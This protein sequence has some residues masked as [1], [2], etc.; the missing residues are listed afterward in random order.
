[1]ADKTNG[2]HWGDRLRSGVDRPATSPGDKADD[3][4]DEEE[5]DD[6]DHRTGQHRGIVRDDETSNSVLEWDMEKE[7]S[8]T[9]LCGRR[10][11]DAPSP[12]LARF[13]T[14]FSDSLDDLELDNYSASPHGR[15]QR[16]RS[17]GD[18][19][20]NTVDGFM[21]HS[22]DKLHQS[23]RRRSSPS[24]C[25]HPLIPALSFATLAFFL[26]LAFGYLC[27]PSNSNVT[28]AG[29]TCEG[30]WDVR[31]DSKMAGLRARVLGN[32]TED[33]VVAA[34]RGQ[35]LGSEH[36]TVQWLRLQWEQAG[37]QDVKI[38]E[39]PG[40]RIKQRK[41]KFW[42]LKQEREIVSE[43]SCFLNSG[44]SCS[45][46]EYGNTS[47]RDLP[48]PAEVINVWYGRD[49]DLNMS[50]IVNLTGRI[51]LLKTG[52]APLLFKLRIL[53]KLEAHWA[54]V[55]TDPSCPPASDGVFLGSGKRVQHI[56]E[57]DDRWQD[58]VP[59]PFEYIS[60][61]LAW[62]LHPRDPHQPCRKTST[63]LSPPLV[64]IEV[65]NLQNDEHSYTITGCLPAAQEPDRFVLLAGSHGDVPS[66][67]VVMATLALAVSAARRSGWRPRRSL[68]FCSWGLA[69]PESWIEAHA[70]LLG[71]NAVAYVGIGTLA[72]P[73]GSLLTRASPSLQ[74][75][76]ADSLSE[77]DA[78]TTFRNS[79][80]LPMPPHAFLLENLGL[81]TITFFL[82]HPAPSPTTKSENVSPTPGLPST[83][84]LTA[85]PAQLAR[86]A[87]VAAY[88]AL[89][90]AD[91]PVLPFRVVDLALMV[92]NYVNNL[93]M[94]A[95]QLN[96]ST[97]YTV[98]QVLRS[99]AEDLQSDMN[100][101]AN[102]PAERPL[103]RLRMLNDA[104]QR[105]TRSFIASHLPLGLSRNILMRP[106]GVRH[107]TFPPLQAL[108]D[109]GE[110]NLL[111]NRHRSSNDS[112]ASSVL[113]RIFYALEA[114][115]VA[116][117]SAL[118]IFKNEE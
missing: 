67:A 42:M 83:M 103:F 37:L 36:Q 29:A 52:Y 70:G 27:Q 64:H 75:L 7:L 21:F 16:L 45:S 78:T 106:P 59:L 92:Q 63:L 74:Q 115:E 90:L 109:M 15:F 94:Q 118:D 82:P 105:L 33:A 111:S 53:A 39:H 46:D 113:M 22:T 34:A 101:P 100:R 81:A 71:G 73:Q 85:A 51:V 5:E 1:M 6:E 68:L 61:E 28:N 30:V 96:A 14:G 4:E 79:S 19:N 102:D 104:L 65:T 38:T 84:T 55:Y 60:T 93:K 88:A 43:W 40:F 11:C 117:R 20:Q 87:K 2:R 99:T 114:V 98:A 44:E 66:D 3:D 32:L 77:V 9:R 47:T 116:T 108:L 58:T 86:L 48:N 41:V 8:E 72:G 12:G 91:D 50:R 57:E 110:D 69:G 49:S 35:F 17:D 80:V 112:T 31:S 107:G 24:C 10:H 76:A 62:R 23:A 95:P 18:S 89:R 25:R 26:G 54:L 97:M 56:S 13:A